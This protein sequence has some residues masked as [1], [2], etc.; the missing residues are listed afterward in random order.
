MDAVF[1]QER[2]SIYQLRGGYDLK[3]C[4]CEE[5]QESRFQKK[6]KIPIGWHQY[7]EVENILLLPALC[8]N[9]KYLVEICIESREAHFT[10]FRGRNL[11]NGVPRFVIA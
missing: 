2:N 5:I 3:R 7:L 1:L 10:D 9:W 8:Q 11:Q 4:Y 6:S